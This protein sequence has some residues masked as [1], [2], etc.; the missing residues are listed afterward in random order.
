MCNID[1]SGAT[2]MM[3]HSFP[4]VNEFDPN[5]GDYGLGFFGHSVQAG[6]YY[7]Q[8]PQWGETCYLC[9]VS[10]NGDETGSVSIR[11]RDSYRQRVFLAPLGLYIVTRTGVITAVDFDQSQGLVT[12]SLSAAS[13]FDDED[14]TPLFSRFVVEVRISC[15]VRVSALMVAA[16]RTLSNK[17]SLTPRDRPRGS[18]AR[19][20][21]VALPKIHLSWSQ[22]VHRRSSDVFELAPSVVQQPAGDYCHQARLAF[23]VH[24]A[25]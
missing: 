23:T 10:N 4:F 5:S 2:S 21:S 6:A 17:L 24:T 1:E 15:P 8:H 3:F 12:V 18:Q 19:Q 22:G 16:Q 9:D 13:C 14:T 25:E 7:V 11:P 20:T